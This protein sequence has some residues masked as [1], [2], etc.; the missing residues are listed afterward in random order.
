ML[1]RVQVAVLGPLEVRRDGVPVDLGAPKPRSVL[2]AL[3]LSAG[4]P[5]SVDALLDL[6]WGDSPTPGAISTLHAYVSGL[7]KVLEPDRSRRQAATVLVTQ[8]PGYA[9]RVA[10][11]DLDA[12]V[13]T[14]TVTSWHRR[15]SGP[16]VGDP[17][18]PA[19]VL[20]EGVGALDDALALWRGEAYAELGDLPA[21]VA[22]RGHLEELRLVA[23]EDRAW[24]GLALGD[25]ATVAAEL[26]T[27]TAAHPLRERLWALR[28]L[29]LVRSGRQAEA[30]DTLRRVREV[31][32]DELGLDPGVELQQLQERI[33]RQDGALAWTPPPAPGPAA[34]APAAPADPGPGTEGGR[35]AGWP[36]LGRDRDLQVLQDALTAA[37][38]G[39][40]A[41]AVV[42]GEPGI[43]K[44]R[45][46]AEVAQRARE[47]GTRVLVGRCSQDDGA[48]PLYP[49][50]DVLAGLGAA[51]PAPSGEGA[52][53]LVWEQIVGA[54]RGAAA[55]QPCVLVVDDLHWA[56]TASLRALRLLVETSTDDALLVLLTWRD[57]PAPTGALADLADALARRHAE[58]VGLT[59]LDPSTITAL[60]DALTEQ[61]PTPDQSA[62]LRSRTDGN[63]FFLV[64]YARL[65]GRGGDLADLLRDEPPTVVQDVVGR[66][67]GRL[68]EDTLRLLGVAAV[69]GRRFD[70]GVLALTAERDE[71]A[72]LDLLD[73]PQALG[74]V[75]EDGVDRFAFD[76][77]LVRDTLVARTP[78]SR[79]A[80]HHAKAALALEGTAGR[81]TEIARHW[82][83]AGPGHAAR[84]WR[85][86]ESAAAVSLAASAPEEAADLL[87]RALAALDDDPAAADRDRWRLLVALGTAQRW[88]GRWTELTGTVERAIAVAQR[89]DPEAVAEAATLTLRGAH[90]QSAQ[91]GSANHEIIAALRRCL[92]ELPPDDSPLR[93]RALITLAGELY[94]VSGTRERH[95]L[96]DEALAMARRLDAPDLLVD[97]LLGTA[98]ALWHPGTEPDRLAW[99][100]EALEVAVGIGDVLAEVS[101]RTQV[102]HIQAALGRPDLM[103]PSY[104]EARA[105]AV[106]ARMPY[107][108]V[109]LDTLVV[110][111]LV[112]AGRDDEADAL[113]AECF[114]AL[115]RADL[116]QAQDAAAGLFATMSLWRGTPIP[117]EVFDAALDAPLPAETL[118]AWTL[119]RTGDVEGAL[120][121]MAEHPPRLDH[122]DWFSLLAWAFAGGLAAY[123][124]DADLGA[125]AYALL[126]PYAG[127]TAVAGSGV[128]SGPVDGYLALAA[129][130]AGETAT[131]TAHADDAAVLA[132]RWGLP[133]YTAWLAEVRAR[134]GF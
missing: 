75:R 99:C 43:G 4:R 60:V 72:V 92:T 51:L 9:L 24:A 5:V 7:R 77:A 110:A 116:N 21:A 44:S 79:R 87:G 42:T 32:G 109:V 120:R 81:E 96:C 83:E 45:L 36:M 18:V 35:G 115:T 55:E 124:E 121:F 94:Y 118:L 90:W 89:L 117:R 129:W 40:T 101:A 103:W 98:T 134:F 61:R 58:R 34:P 31:L 54:V 19:D 93:C 68:P 8:A 26:E 64:E 123:A 133:R 88:G 113:L 20:A 59:G 100:Q 12:H 78:V 106:R 56:D 41:F 52:E 132:Q 28:A 112:L 126:A 47:R 46:C 6:V 71:E 66:R 38:A 57:R 119:V 70:L 13:F 37:T 86:A 62:A 104:D 84:A 127:R 105:L 125:R 82:L 29:A 107:A 10:P 11:S 49:W 76:H 27:L 114:E 48:P 91:H 111:W 80:R 53:F 23:L 74:L 69:L 131:A 15:L 16:L 85:A 102:S 73:L 122:D 33:L 65:L 1:P 108:L 22:E 30:L 2:T 128:A 97:V 50:R 67:L 14:T 25:D 3:A 17:G 95:A 63:P 130:A 39:T